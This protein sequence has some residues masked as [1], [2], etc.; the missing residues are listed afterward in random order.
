[1]VRP[2]AF[3]A[4]EQTAGTNAFQRSAPCGGGEAQRRALVEFDA[5]VAALEEAGV[6]VIAVEDRLGLLDSV[7]PNN[8]VSWHGG[9]GGTALV[10]V[11]PM[12]AP[13]RRRERDIGVVEAVL[14]RTGLRAEVVDLTRYEQQ[15]RFLEGTGSL[16]LERA[17]RVAFACRSARTDERLARQVCDRLGYDLV[18]FDAAIADVPIYHT[19]VMMWVGADLAGVCLEAI[20]DAGERRGVRD[21]L[22]SMAKTVLE[23]TVE[24]VVHFAGNALELRART[25]ER[26]LAL[27]ETAWDAMDPAQRRLIEARARPVTAAIPT[28]ERLGGGSMR[29]MLAEVGGG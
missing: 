1:M 19:N 11:Y 28:I 15:G 23:L 10:V 25:G 22:E 18:P 29:C 3:G 21:R 8:W 5:A 26:V 12:L 2:S 9:A 16:V 13:N 14:G 20:G 27:S 7:F 24:Q 6:D 4:N 17:A